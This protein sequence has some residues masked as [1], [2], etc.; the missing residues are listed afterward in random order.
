MTLISRY[1][2][3]TFGRIFGLA[4]AAFIG[5]YLLVDFFE[6]VDTFIEYSA[7]ADLYLS[8]FALK[9]PFIAV[10]V[11]PLACLLAVFMTLGGF[12]RSNELMAMHS[13]GISLLRIT[14]PLLAT[15]LLISLL[16]LLTYEYLVPICVKQAN[17]IYT[18]KV[19]GHPVAV[20][21]RS[22]IWLRDGNKIVNIRL[23]D[24]EKGQI[25]GVTLFDFDEHFKLTDRS[26]I[27]QA[28]YI[29]GQ[30]RAKSLIERR[31]DNGNPIVSQTAKDQKV[32][33]NL[34][35]EDF[36]V[37][38]S[39]RNEDLG[40]R[41]LRALATKLKA[42]GYDPTRFEV[43]M[44]SRLA[45]PLASLIMAFLGIPFALRKGRDSSLALGVAMSIMIGVAYFI[46][47]AMLLAFGYS[48]AL[49]PV[50][51]A[52]AANLLFFLFGCWLFLGTDS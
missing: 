39:K 10:Q 9:I 33:L 42:E 30:W 41:E 31:F 43:D 21:K 36:R 35:P 28:D 11:V 19:R 48:S 4:L 2:L 34:T 7:T 12:S 24:A 6:R 50:L 26:D 37:A 40:F 17:L 38:G 25:Q 13:A 1:I 49:P 18:G 45:T 3:S 22:R 32:D 44:H 16:T 14:L 20:F 23:A 52:W 46:L 27:S 15:G 29:N 47:Q 51:A 8:Y 5:L